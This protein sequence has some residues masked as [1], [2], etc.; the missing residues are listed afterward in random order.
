MKNLITI[1]DYAKLKDVHPTNVHYW[2]KKKYLTV[3]IVGGKKFIDK[4]LVPIKV[5]K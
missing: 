3:Q 5:M 4:R 1:S 2:I